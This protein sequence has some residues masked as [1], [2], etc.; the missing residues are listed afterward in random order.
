MGLGSPAERFAAEEMKVGMADIE[1]SAPGC[2]RRGHP[3]K[4]ARR[5]GH[6][7]RRVPLQ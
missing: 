2:L 6:P 1:E 3:A 7:G 5:P 4:G